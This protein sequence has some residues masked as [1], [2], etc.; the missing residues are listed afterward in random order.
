F[1]PGD[2]ELG[3]V[4]A[5]FRAAESVSGSRQGQTL[6]IVDYSAG[7]VSMSVSTNPESRAVFFNPDGTLLPTLDFT[8]LWGLRQGYAEVVGPRGAA[9]ALGFGSSVGVYLDSPR[10]A[11]GSYRRRLRTARTPTIV[12]PRS[13][14]ATLPAFDPARVRPEVVWAVLDGMLTAETFTLDQEWSCVAAD[15]EG[16]GT[17]RLYF[18]V[19]DRSVVTDL[20]GGSV[21]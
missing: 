12:T 3:D 7:L 2:F 9:S 1:D 13:D 10:E 4:G 19:G 11:D 16:T 18:T 15:R 14:A 6:Q 20:D 17:P 21:E 5:L 8:S